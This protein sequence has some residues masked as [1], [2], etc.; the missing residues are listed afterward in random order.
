MGTEAHELPHSR[1]PVP[2]SG[3]GSGRDQFVLAPGVENS[4]TLVPVLVQGEGI[5]QKGNGVEVVLDPERHDEA[6]CVGSGGGG[7]VAD[8]GTCTT[9]PS[10]PGFVTSMEA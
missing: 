1:T 3:D 4:N 8:G 6:H 7:G 5:Q 9:F 10:Q 2:R